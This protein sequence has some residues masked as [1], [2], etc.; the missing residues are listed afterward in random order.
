MEN[1]QLINSEAYRMI[2]PLNSTTCRC[3]DY[4]GAICVVWCYSGLVSNFQIVKAPV[5]GYQA[6]NV[7]ATCPAGSYVIGCHPYPWVIGGAIYRGYY[8]SSSNTCTCRDSLGIQC[9][10]TCASNVRN[11]E[12]KTITGTGTLQVVCSPTTVVLGC[13][14]NPLGN[15][16]N[17]FTTA[18]VVDDR[19]CQCSDINGA[20]CYA[21]CGELYY[22]RVWATTTDK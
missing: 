16:Q 20:T 11:H 18:F 19:T 10:A 9:I 7:Y 6:G 2:I 4:Y 17:K 8:P 3:Y 15:G 21:I 22:I 14:V 13:G 1:S 12:I 5:T